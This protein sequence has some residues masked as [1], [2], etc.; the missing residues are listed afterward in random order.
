[1]YEPLYLVN[2]LIGKQTH[3]LATRYKWVGNKEAQYTIRSGVKWSNGQP[4]TA[5]HVVFTFNLLKKYPAVDLTGIWSFISSVSASGN[6]VTFNFSTPN[7]PG[8]QDIL[9]QEIVCPPQFK[10]VN[11]ATFTDASLIV[12]GSYVLD[13][14]HS[15][16]YTLKVKPL[17]GQ[18]SLIKV[19][20]IT[21]V[22]VNGEASTLQMAEGKFDEAILFAPNIQKVYAIKNPKY[23]HY[24]FP[25]ADQSDI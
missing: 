20:E 23:Y 2:S 3:W 6:V 8:L 11:L 9:N 18:R 5:Q 22:S 1:M 25:L 17:Y 24:W 21:E 14:F 12:T 4:F 13:T 19:P 10:N 16:E 7:V 15:T